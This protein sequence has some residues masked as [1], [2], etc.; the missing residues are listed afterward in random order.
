MLK[1][2]IKKFSSILTSLEARKSKVIILIPTRNSELLLDLFFENLYKLV[3]QPDKY[4]FCENNSSDKTLDKLEGFKLPHEIIRIW[5]SD[6]AVER[7]GSPYGVIAHVRQLLLTRARKIDP[8]YAIFLDDDVMVKSPDMIRVLTRWNVDIVGGSYIRSW[9]E[10]FYLASLWKSH[11]PKE[12]LLCR[13]PAKP[14]DEP[15]VT[16]AGCLCLSRRI[17]QDRRINFHP[18]PKIP[19]AAPSEDFGYCYQARQYGYKIYLDGLVELSH[20]VHVPGRDGKA[21]SVGPSM[22]REARETH[23]LKQG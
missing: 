12:Y 19:N 14:L 4:V 9:P 6:D 5:L 18:L 2:G 3:P 10:G 1:R 7:E 20:C 13:R 16:G 11:D 21:W 23:V 17:I 22:N 15:F 8:D